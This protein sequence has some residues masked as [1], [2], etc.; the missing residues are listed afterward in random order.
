MKRL[1]CII[2]GTYVSLMGYADAAPPSR[3]YDYTPLTTIQS[4]HVAANENVIFTYLQ[5]G[6]DT[7]KDSSIVDADVSASAAITAS[8]LNLTTVSQNISNTGTMANTGS[9]TIVGATSLTGDVRTLGTLVVSGAST[10][11]GALTA[12][13]Y[14]LANGDTVVDYKEVAAQGE[15]LYFDGTDWRPLA[16]GTDGYFLKTSGA[17][18]NPSWASVKETAAGDELR[19]SAD[20]E[21]NSNSGPYVKVKEI[22]IPYSG[23]LRIKFDL[24]GSAAV[25]DVK[26]QVRRNDVAVG[27]EQSDTDNTYTNKSEDISGWSAGDKVQLWYHW[28]GGC[29]VYV[30]NFRIYTDGY[31]SVDTD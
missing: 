25:C 4:D 29:N 15:V 19:A 6:V 14:S 8:K 17:G 11:S 30:R 24:K 13:S 5:A 27:T 18:A 16:V 9:L 3:V 21:R 31:Y 2:F 20:T 22:T 12:A 28:D 26:A 10:F 23:T 1:L 7:I